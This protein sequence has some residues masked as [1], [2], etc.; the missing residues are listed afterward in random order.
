[1]MEGL[2]RTAYRAT[3]RVEDVDTGKRGDLYAYDPKTGRTTKMPEAPHGLVAIP[4]GDGGFTI[5]A[6]TKEEAEAKD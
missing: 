2:Q 6:A 5:R 3:S 1:M 4:D